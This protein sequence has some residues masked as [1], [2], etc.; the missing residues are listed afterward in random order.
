M[1]MYRPTHAQSEQFPRNRKFSGV[2]ITQQR[3]HYDGLTEAE[4]QRLW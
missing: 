4:I 2:L 1:H 3:Q